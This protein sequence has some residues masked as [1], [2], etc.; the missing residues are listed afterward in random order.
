VPVFL[1]S[2]WFKVEPIKAESI[3][4]ATPEISQAK[5][6]NTAPSKA[7]PSAASSQ[8]N[9]SPVEA[10]PVLLSADASWSSIMREGES[11]G[12]LGDSLDFQTVLNEFDADRDGWAELLIHSDLGGETTIALYLYSDLGLAPLKTPFRRDSSSPE[13][14]V[15]P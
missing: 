2:A 12:N 15:D 8:L 6:S 4:G 1:M 10:A 9:S 14:C 13:S 3:K 7:L 11:A 5:A